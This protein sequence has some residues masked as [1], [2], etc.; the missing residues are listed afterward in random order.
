M[1]TEYSRGLVYFAHHHICKLQTHSYFTSSTTEVQ[2]FARRVFIGF[3]LVYM[4]YVH[5]VGSRHVTDFGI[6]SH[7]TLQGY[8]APHYTFS[9]YKQPFPSTCKVTVHPVASL[10]AYSYEYTEHLWTNDTKASHVTSASPTCFCTSRQGNNFRWHSHPRLYSFQILV[11]ST[12]TQ[13][14]AQGCRVHILYGYIFSF[15][16]SNSLFCKLQEA[17]GLHSMSALS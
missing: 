14:Q 10:M 3:K 13:T 1:H 7:A 2:A 9:V 8:S 4:D 12:T 17:R 11:S 16:P 15:R 6:G 5:G